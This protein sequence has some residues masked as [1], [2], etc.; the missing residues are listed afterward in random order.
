[1]SYPSVTGII[2]P[3]NV[4]TLRFPTPLSH[5]TGVYSHRLYSVGIRVLYHGRGVWGRLRLHIKPNSKAASAHI[6]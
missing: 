6:S 2:A 4:G 1:M 3:H 5:K